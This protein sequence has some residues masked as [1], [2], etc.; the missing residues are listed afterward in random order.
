MYEGAVLIVDDD[1]GMRKSLAVTLRHDGYKVYCAENGMAAL[2][3]VKDEEVQIV[4]LDLKMPG[5]D[6][7][8]TLKRI[9]AFRNNIPVIMITGFG[10]IET[11]VEAMKLGAFDYVTKPFETTQ[12]KAIVKNA[13]K[14]Q[15]LAKENE[16]LKGALQ[17]RFQLGS[18]I[19]KSPKMQE[20]YDLIDKVAPTDAT[21]VLLGESGTGKEL[22]AKCIHYNSPRRNGPFIKLNC[23]ALPEGV[24]DSELFG[25]EKGAFTGATVQ[26]LGRFELAH[27][28]TIFLDE[29]G[30][31]SPATQVRLLRVLQE[32][33]FERVGGTQTIKTDA[34]IIVATNKDLEREM[35]AGRFR[36]DLYYRLNVI[37]I[38][39]PPLRE[40]MEDIPLLVDYFLKEFCALHQKHVTQVAPDAMKA[41]MSYRWPGNIRELRNVIERGVVLAT[42]DLVT[43]D[44]LP[45]EITTSC[46]DG[47]RHRFEHG[48]TLKDVVDEVVEEVEREVILDALSKCGWRQAKVAGLLGISEK[49]LYNKMQKYHIR[50]ERDE[51]RCHGP[52]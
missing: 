15:A 32:R 4:I 46:P 28:G 41:L 37:R 19:G 36:E 51:I 52:S 40:R 45:E 17:E 5:P 6:G 30:D 47:R 49:T 33:E 22:V 50:Q 7:L 31:I 39:M 27:G 2:E 9:K 44:L 12:I 38:F 10:S 26:R 24:L 11:A 35:L 21:V 13:L 42:G 23:A 43:V 8:E 18:I 48:K 20:I 16:Y 25:H 1:E 34:R 3:K 14:L 29:I